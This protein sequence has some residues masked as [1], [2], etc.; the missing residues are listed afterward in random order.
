MRPNPHRLRVVTYGPLRV[1]PSCGLWSV[2]D[3]RSRQGLGEWERSRGRH[4]VYSPVQTLH[5]KHWQ[6]GLPAR[7]WGR[8]DRGVGGGSPSELRANWLT[9]ESEALSQGSDERETRVVVGVPR[10]LMGLPPR[11]PPGRRTGL[12]ANSALSLFFILC[13]FF[14]S[15]FTF[16]FPV[17]IFSPSLRFFVHEA[18][19]PVVYMESAA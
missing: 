13:S 19:F 2:A 17:F 18:F 5:C 16:S 6:A 11:P 4:A 12:P 3:L 15:F 1:S 9:G 8:G 7:G 10:S 14:L